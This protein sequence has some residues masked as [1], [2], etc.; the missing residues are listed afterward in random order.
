MGVEGMALLRGIKQA[1]DPMLVL[2]AGKVV[3]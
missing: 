3:A 2:M 1:F